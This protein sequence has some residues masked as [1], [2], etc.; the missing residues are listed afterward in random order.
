MRRTSASWRCFEIIHSGLKASLAWRMSSRS[1]NGRSQSSAWF[2]SSLERADY[3][4]GAAKREGR[5][6]VL[7]PPCEDL[8]DL[9]KV[10]DVVAGDHLGD[11]L[12]G[13]LS[14]FGMYTKMLPLLGREQF[15]K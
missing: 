11:T 15:V 3:F 8:L 14:A 1:R 12:D 9:F 10:I 4:F 13:F 2:W 5:R 7:T 6:G